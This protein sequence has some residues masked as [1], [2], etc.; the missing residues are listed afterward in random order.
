MHACKRCYTTWGLSSVER[1]LCCVAQKVQRKD[2][3]WPRDQGG[4]VE[5]KAFKHV[6][7]HEKY[8]DICI[9]LCAFLVLPTTLLTPRGTGTQNLDI[10]IS[11]L[12]VLSRHQNKFFFKTYF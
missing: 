2:F 9:C 1:T 12:S 5:E 7:K 11:L 6:F 8:G 3:F 4:F 10:F